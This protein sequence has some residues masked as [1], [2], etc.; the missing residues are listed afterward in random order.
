MVSLCLLDLHGPCMSVWH[1]HGMGP[2]REGWAFQGQNGNFS[3]LLGGDEAGLQKLVWLQWSWDWF[4][5]SSTACPLF[6]WCRGSWAE[7]H[8]LPSVLR[9]CPLPQ[10]V[11]AVC[12]GTPQCEMILI[13]SSQ[14]QGACLQ[15]G[16]LFCQGLHSHTFYFGGMNREHLTVCGCWVNYCDVTNV[17]ILPSGYLLSHKQCCIFY[18]EEHGPLC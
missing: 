11:C 7:H 9:S 17:G 13:C 6:Q 2:G 15:P 12:L 18:L 10:A 5:L 16:R 8:S 3:S 14:S 4:S 1:V